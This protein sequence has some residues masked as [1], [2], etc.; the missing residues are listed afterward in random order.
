MLK[1]RTQ[2]HARIVVKDVLGAVAVMH[3][4]IRDRHPAQAMRC[5]R[6]R[7]SD[8]NV[9]EDTEAHRPRPFG[10]V[11]GRTDVAKGVLH[12]ASH[13][14]IHAHHC[15]SRGTQRSRIAKGVHA[16]VAIELDPAMLRRVGCDKVDIG[17]GVHAQ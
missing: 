15:G 17:S 13:H 5:Q 10:M 1:G 7:R 9:V 3:I 2:H 16:G 8:G 11:T 12:L 14:Q 6:M 4:E